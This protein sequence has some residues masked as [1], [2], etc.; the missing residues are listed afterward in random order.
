MLHSKPNIKN[1]LRICTLALSKGKILTPTIAF[2]KKL[3]IELPFMGHDDR[4]L[5]FD[6]SSN[7]QTYRILLARATDVPTY[8]EHGVADI[9]I[10]GSDLLA[11]QMREL[12]ELVDLGFGQCRLVVAEPENAKKRQGLKPRIATKYPN[13]TERFFAEKGVP[14]EIIKLYGSVELAPLVGLADQIVDLTE[15]GRTLKAQGLKIVEEIASCS[16]RM[17]VNRVSFKLNYPQIF[18]FI[19]A[20]KRAVK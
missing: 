13:M 17:I 14:I 9:G 19:E 10:V 15:T 6:T 4:R 7:N 3:D 12:Y 5:I 16:A 18:H 20:T 2:L 1:P 8:V 11:E